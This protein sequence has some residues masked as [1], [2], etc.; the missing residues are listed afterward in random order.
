MIKEWIAKYWCLHKWNEIKAT[1]AYDLDRK[2]D[3]MPMYREYLYVCE[4][5]GEF[6]KIR[7]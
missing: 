1:E 7:L 4:K 3:T 6:K 5:C 2:R